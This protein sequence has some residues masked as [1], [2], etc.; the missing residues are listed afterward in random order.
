LC[1]CWRYATAAAAEA[2]ALLSHFCY[3]CVVVSVF[4]YFTAIGREEEKE[5]EQITP[6]GKM[7]NIMV[8]SFV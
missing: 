3:F 8:E 1:A 6:T 7:L 4:V 2:S 5:K